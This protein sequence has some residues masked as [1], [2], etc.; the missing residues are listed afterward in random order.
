MTHPTISAWSTVSSFGIGRDAFVEGLRAG[1]PPPGI[2]GE[3]PGTVAHLV[4]GFTPAAALGKKGTRSMDRVTGLAVSVVGDLLGGRQEPG[5]DIGLVLGTTTGSAQSIMDFTH[6]SLV[7]DKPYFVDPARFPNTVMNCA[8]GQCAIWY[9]LRGP[10]TTVAGGRT[11]MLYALTYA[12][13][14]LQAGRAGTVLCGAAEEY[15]PARA[16]LDWHSGARAPLGEGSVVFKVSQ[17]GGGLADVLAV[18]TGVGPAA[19][20]S[21][22]RRALTAAGVGAAE[23]SIVAGDDVPDG[24][25]RD[26]VRRITPDSLLGDTAAAA[27]GFQIAAI[28]AAGEPGDVAIVTSVDRSGSVGCALLRLS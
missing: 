13:R 4:P 27:A 2:P 15:S 16:W 6:D 7:G 26:D 3:V 18:R 9:G 5:D 10:N 25:L 23:V 14:L 1:Q 22:V 11:S 20:A 21:C 28:L 8:A 12:R 17:D 19:L 24:I